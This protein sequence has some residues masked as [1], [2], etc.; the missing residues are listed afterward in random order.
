[1][2]S[3]AAACS[4]PGA[5]APT[6]VPVTKPTSAPAAG[7]TTAPAVAAPTSV[8]AKPA[9][10]EW[11]Q[12]VAAANGEKTV[13]VATY[14]GTG[15][16]KVI[17]AF[18]AAYPGIQVEHSQ[19]QSSSRDYIPR[20]LQEL[21]AGLHSFDLAL[22]PPQ[23]MLRQLRPVD[24][25]T[26]FRPAIIRPDVLDD[27]NWLDSLENGFLDKDKRWGYALV[28]LKSDDFWINTEMVNESEIKSLKDIL[29][30]KWK[31]KIV[32]GDP[33]TKGSGFQPATVM[34]LK[35]GNDDI[36]KQLYVDQEV[37]VSTD[38]RQLTELMVRGRYPIGVGAIDRVI[39]KDFQAQ[40]IGTGLKPI[41]I[42]EGVY[43]YSQTGILWM[44]SNPPHPNAAKVYTNW[45]L[46]KDGGIAW[47]TNIGDN[48]RRA[49]V[50]VADETKTLTKGVQYLNIQAEEL[51]DEQQKTQDLAKQLLN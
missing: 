5:P 2:T 6:A 49:D 33:R 15:H 37:V 3:L 19:F 14:A 27:K 12:V 30:P 45:L 48:S 39:L 7:P 25:L 38:A 4:Q 17:E 36:M 9:A 41:D 51:L 11:D 21:K 44:L 1:M 18:Q 16:R 47:S 50:P 43:Q 28:S 24:G 13:A 10:N 35:T 22:M 31:G 26:P 8:P 46:S 32:G 34:R 23:E 42:P 20:V 40:G 29:D